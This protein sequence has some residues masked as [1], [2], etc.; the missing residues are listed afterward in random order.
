M[1]RLILVIALLVCLF[2]PRPGVCTGSLVPRDSWIN[3]AE[4]WMQLA[5][6][7]RYLGRLQKAAD[8]YR[9]LLQKTPRNPELHAGLAEVEAAR[10]HAMAARDQF[11]S[12]LKLEPG[13]LDLELRQA[14]AMNLW[15]DFYRIE[16]IY[17]GHLARHPKDT[18]VMMLL[19]GALMGAQRFEEAG[20]MYLWLLDR[21]A[22]RGETLAALSRVQWEAGDLEG[23]L[24]YGRL[25][26]ALSPDQA[27]LLAGLGKASLRL[28]RADQALDY[29]VRL[30]AQKGGR[31]QGLTGMGLAY[32]A[33]GKK[34]E[35][36][37]S[38][39]KARKAAPHDPAAIYCSLGQEKAASDSF[40][41]GL[42]RPGATPPKQLTDWAEVYAGQGLYEQAIACHK[43]ALKAD[44]AYF[45]A[46]MALGEILGIAKHYEEAGRILD[47]L[48][49]DF[50]GA[51]KVLITRARVLAW[52]RQYDKAIAQY[53][54]IHRLNPR[55]SLPLRE[56]ARTAVWNKDLDQARELY[57]KIW[58]PP[59]DRELAG[60]A[61]RWSLSA[62]KE[63]GEAA[64]S[65]DGSGQPTR[66]YEELVQALKR[67][68]AGMDP[69]LVK[70]TSLTLTWLR[71]IYRVQKAA[72]LELAAKEA[73]WNRRYLQAGRACRELVEFQPGNQEAWFDLAQAQCALNLLDGQALSYH[74]LLVLDPLHSQAGQALQRLERRGMPRLGAAYSLWAENGYGDL[75]DIKRQQAELDL[76]VPLLGRFEP[77]A[78]LIS[79]LEQPG[80]YDGDAWATGFRIGANGSLT[81]WLNAGLDWTHKQYNKSELGTRDSGSARLGI[82]VQDYLSL[83][84]GWQRQEVLQNSFGLQQGIMTDDWWL[85]LSSQITRRLEASLRLSLVDYSDDNRMNLERLEIG[86]GL[87]DHPRELKLV[88][89]VERRDHEEETREIYSNGELVDIIHPYWAPVNWW[90]GSLGL[91]WRHDLSQEQYCGA[92]KHYY[93]L[94]VQLNDDNE[95]NLGWQAEASWHYEFSDHWDLGLKGLAHNSRKWDAV[96]LWLNLG[97]RF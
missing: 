51:S 8:I 56:A 24:H 65:G 4:A 6:V 92:Q 27:D 82:N 84:L 50:P 36:R 70:E 16:N 40:V 21:G 37:S 7:N 75:A 19:A 77:H 73:L 66:L 13:N 86:Y 25:A 85:G 88:F 68:G 31:A 45:P 17:R 29:Y 44:P 72:G 2:T 32:E 35:A 53:L 42:T 22:P 74:A 83:S 58:Q 67:T 28:G 43:A 39:Q 60:L 96:G 89:N 55:D 59:V 1:P 14:Q 47:K 63:P 94:G 18:E 79:W 33:L 26:L 54:E 80:L 41:K 78:A 69:G 57:R 61:A 34:E 91:K 12:A 49:R 11:N 95:D 3:D 90:G 62:P 52:S 30:A 64:A 15:G 48:A 93:E 5:R 76:Q 81:P 10:G 46:R 9:L 38:F 71:G 20:A 87:S 97:Y 23:C